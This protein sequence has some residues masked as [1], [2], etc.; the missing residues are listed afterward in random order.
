MWDSMKLCA[1]YYSDQYL[2]SQY[3]PHTNPNCAWDFM[4]ACSSVVWIYH[5]LY[6]IFSCVF[7]RPAP[8]CSS[9][10]SEDS[11]LQAVTASWVACNGSV[12]AFGSASISLSLS[13]TQVCRRM[14]LKG[15]LCNLDFV[16]QHSINV[17]LFPVSR[18]AHASRP[19]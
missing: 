17:L 8:V 1:A 6:E 15:I 2:K 7:E 11:T 10:L 9:A 16:R 12:S 5:H 4:L 13:G 3:R 18:R 14:L 19:A